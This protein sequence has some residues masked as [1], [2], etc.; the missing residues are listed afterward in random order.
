MKRNPK[1]HIAPLIALVAVLASVATVSL[2]WGQQ[3][4]PATATNPASIDPLKQRQ[5]DQLVENIRKQFVEAKYH[6]VLKL[7]EQ[8]DALIPNHPSTRLY[9]EW[10]LQKLAATKIREHA[11]VDFTEEG[12]SVEV[13]TPVAPAT[14]TS[15]IETP[16]STP[17]ATRPTESQALPASSTETPPPSRQSSLRV[18]LIAVVF[19]LS[20]AVLVVIVVALRR[21]PAQGGAISPLRSE[22]EKELPRTESPAVGQSGSSLTSAGLSKEAEG[23]PLGTP[24]PGLGLPTFQ[25]GGLATSPHVSSPG[26][27]YPAAE[28]E[29]APSAEPTVPPLPADMLSAESG[30]AELKAISAQ[31]VRSQG[32]PEG[33]PALPELGGVEPQAAPGIVS[34]E[35][36]GIELPS[37]PEPLPEAPPKA[38]SASMDGSRIVISPIKEVPSSAPQ[39]TEPPQPK[40]I[41][42][43][44][45]ITPAGTGPSEIPAL[46]LEDVIERGSSAEASAKAAAPPTPLAEEIESASGPPAL[47]PVSSE[48]LSLDLGEGEL[49]ELTL[50]APESSPSPSTESTEVETVTL[51]PSP[52]EVTLPESVGE[53]EETKTLPVVPENALDLEAALAETKAMEPMSPTAPPASAPPESEGEPSAVTAELKRILAAEPAKESP[54]QEEQVGPTQKVLDERSERMFRD[55]YERGLKAF[56]AK[57]YKQAV[58]Y[59]SIAAA[60]HPE[61]PE[62]REKLRQAREF[63]R[64]QESAH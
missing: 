24:T 1:K 2:L 55:Q 58:Y 6:E 33:V 43:A 18:V 54:E 48:S 23:A 5:F 21:R 64:R 13:P 45:E 11:D 35:E 34:F 9:R 22:E 57:N 15:A 29:A 27:E 4:P 60:I 49:D 38:Y 7:C 31:A 51:A 50:V 44:E 42:I 62:V 12:R 41:D 25:F 61:N 8:A 52:A 37:E 14:P 26:A 20:A 32:P 47:E 56:E 63:K 53:L 28:P 16:P 17:A 30:A 3:M 46:S 10:S 59:L 19:I 40:K 39:R 36:L